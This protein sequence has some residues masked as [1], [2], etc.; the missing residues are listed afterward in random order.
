[1]LEINR[2]EDIIIPFQKIGESDWETNTHHILEALADNWGGEFEKCPIS[3][4]K[5]T[6]LEKRLNTQL[7]ESLRMFYQTFGIVDIGEELV[8]IDQIKYLKE[9][10]DVPQYTPDFSES[11]LEVLPHLVWFGDYLGNGN[12]FCFHNQTKAIYYFDHDSKPYLTKLFDDFSDYLKAC[13]I[14]AQTDLFGDVNEQDV[15]QWTEE[16]ISNLFGKAILKK[17]RY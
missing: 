10:W 13:L 1:M 7:P 3:E 6:A 15:E 4:E 17:W 12:M 5:I 11:D 2:K 16:I 8:K 14:L 9:W